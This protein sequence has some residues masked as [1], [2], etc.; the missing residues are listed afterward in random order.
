MATIE[1]YVNLPSV[2]DA[3]E[4]LRKFPA[5]FTAPL[6]KKAYR[7]GAWEEYISP[8]C[9]N[10]TYYTRGPVVEKGSRI[11]SVADHC[12]TILFPIVILV[13]VWFCNCSI[14]QQALL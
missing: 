3:K 7:Q 12:L 1:N 2:A 9:A 6:S 11:F 5:F 8:K 4:I 14:I 13:C 10:G